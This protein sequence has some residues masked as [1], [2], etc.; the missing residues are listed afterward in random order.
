MTGAHERSAYFGAHIL[1]TLLG[2]L[3][4]CA[5][6][7]LFYHHRPGGMCNPVR[8]KPRRWA[9]TYTSVNV[10]QPLVCGECVEAMSV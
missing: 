6:L 5:V 9:A 3:L 10:R 1:P 2:T 4:L 7:A 8:S